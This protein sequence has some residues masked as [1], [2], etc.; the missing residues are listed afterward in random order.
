M[1]VDD[2]ISSLQALHESDVRRAISN[3]AVR[4]AFLQIVKLFS[5]S[6]SDLLLEGTSA[7]L[8]WLHRQS[9]EN[10]S[11]L[12]KLLAEEL[13]YRGAQIERLIQTSEAHREFA[14]EDLR[15]LVL[16]A[17]RRSEGL[18]DR[19]RIQRLA[20]ILVRASELGRRDL[21]DYAEE[22]LRIATNLNARDVFVLR[23]IVRVQGSRI[24]KDIGRVK[25]Y[26][27]YSV[28]RDIAGTLKQAGFLQGEVD[29]I[30]A[31]LESFG[32]VSRTER[33]ISL[34]GDDP[35]P[36]ALLQRGLDF[37]DYIKS[38]V[39]LGMTGTAAPQ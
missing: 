8:D 11:E 10:L 23:E 39:E 4:Q 31:K 3:L 18:R 17:M 14:A 35:T 25:H 32:L 29:S 9:A 2:P 20:R 28:V 6:G 16:E 19:D 13:K 22:M 7:A 37:M 24:Q 1:P 34:L 5:P 21:A 33:N 30:S 27:A 36:Y 15:G 38:A 26:E 12:V